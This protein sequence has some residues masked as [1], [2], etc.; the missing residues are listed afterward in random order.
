MGVLGDHLRD[1]LDGA[2]NLDTVLEPNN[3][4]PFVALDGFIRKERSNN[5]SVLLAL[6]H[7]VYMSMVNEI[8]SK[9][10]V[11][12]GA[13]RELANVFKSEDGGSVCFV[14]VAHGRK[15][16]KGIEDMGATL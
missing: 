1:T 16:E 7:N 11:H 5:V 3:G 12:D 15:W 13:G 14:G 2:E 6:A 4:G 8:A 10:A 9:G